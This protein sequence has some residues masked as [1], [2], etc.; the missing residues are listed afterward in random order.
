M[1]YETPNSCYYDN[2]SSN[3]VY[4]RLYNSEDALIACPEG[5]DLP[6]DD[7]WARLEGLMDTS[8]DY[9]D[10]E[11]NQNGWRGENAGGRM[12]DASDDFWAS[13]NV[14]AV[15]VYGFRALPGGEKLLSNFQYLTKRAYFWTKSAD[16]Q[17]RVLFNEHS[18][19]FRGSFAGDRS[20]SVRCVKN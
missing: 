20:Y 3:E 6:S 2:S 14:G 13:P 5:W 18:D 1:N 10:E 8:Y 9:P 4:G 15:D 7:D 17:C 16:V 12:K 11:W 19:I